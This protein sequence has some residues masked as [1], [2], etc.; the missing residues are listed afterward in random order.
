MKVADVTKRVSWKNMKKMRRIGKWILR[1]REWKKRD[2]RKDL[3]ISIQSV[4]YIFT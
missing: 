3:I 2:E 4:C 1:A